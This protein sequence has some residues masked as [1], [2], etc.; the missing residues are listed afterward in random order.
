MLTN[1]KDFLLEVRL[2]DIS[3]LK[4]IEGDVFNKIETEIER[5]FR[6]ERD[7][8]KYHTLKKRSGKK[9][10]RFAIEYYDFILHN[11]KK[12]IGERTSF[13]TVEEFNDLIERM[14]DYI[15]PDNVHKLLT[16]GKY[17]AYF[18]E[19]NI[20]IIFY[21]NINDYISENYKIKI[22]TLLP[23]LDEKSLIKTFFIS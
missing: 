18:A 21:F 19:N 17:G 22:I 9:K 14:L 5:D 16:P 1:F 11:I 15:F 12:K 3:K 20:E 23:K 6:I 4:G 7:L 13:K 10:V 8:I 2:S